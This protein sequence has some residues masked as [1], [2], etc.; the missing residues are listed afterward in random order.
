VDLAYDE[1]DN[2]V[3]LADASGAAAYTYDALNRLTETERTAGILEDLAIGYAYDPAGNRT[4]VVYPDSKTVRYGYNANEWLISVVDGMGGTTSYAYDPVGLPVRIDYPNNTWTDYTYDAADRL[5]HLFNGKPDTSSNVISSFDYTLDRVGNRVRTIERATRG[6]VI[7]WDKTYEYDPLYRLTEAVFTPDYNPAQVYTSAFAYDAVGNRTSMTTNISDAPN[8]PP[9][10]A[11]VTTEYTYNDANQMLTAGDTEFAYDNNGNRVSMIGAERVINYTY[12]F[13]NRLAGAETFDVQPNGNLQYDSTLDFTYDGLGRRLQR[14]VID[15][16]VRKTASFLYD[17]LGYD[18]LAQYV[19]PGSPRTT[20]YYRDLMQILSR[21]EIQGAGNGLQ[22][23]H[24][25]DGLG[26]VSA[27]T[28]QSGREVQ[29]YTYAPYGRLMDNN[30]PDNS[31]NRTDPHNNLTWS[32]KPWDKETELYYYGARDYDPTT[33]TW[34][35]QDPYRGRVIEPM[36]LQRYM[37]VKD[38]PINLIDRY[39]FAATGC[40]YTMSCSSGQYQAQPTGCGYNMSCEPPKSS[41]SAVSNTRSS[42]ILNGTASNPSGDSDYGGT[43][44]TGCGYNMS[45]SPQQPTGCGYNMSCSPQQPTGCGYNMSCNSPQPTGCGYTMSCDSA[46]TPSIRK[47]FFQKLRDVS[48]QFDILPGPPGSGILNLESC[49]SLFVINPALPVVCI[50]VGLAAA[51]Y[52]ITYDTITNSED[53]GNRNL[54]PI[55]QGVLKLAGGATKVVSELW[56]EAMNEDIP[57]ESAQPRR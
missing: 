39:G 38:N 5:V 14:G 51:A 41:G 25:Y 30:G 53:M 6:Q 54:R 56:R 28:N 7:T 19:D 33:G 20:Y 10:P 43:R 44:P 15:N 16:G 24:H 4:Q 8:T 29:E 21:H 32:G 26:D 52:D 36:T 57:Q 31:S 37:Y 27:W 9:A 12:D 11:P 40:G 1:N 18:L 49:A 3:T 22:Y 50:K 55:W 35:E 45:C 47:Q 23:F 46:Q 34:L 17:G 48:G 2:L 42:T 13:E